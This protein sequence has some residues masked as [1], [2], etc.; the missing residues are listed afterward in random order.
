MLS[1]VPPPTQSPE[2]E[3]YPAYVIVPAHPKLDSQQQYIATLSFCYG[4]ANTYIEVSAES[5]TALLWN[6]QQTDTE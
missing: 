6:A 3:M 1:W 4:T 2:D 5:T